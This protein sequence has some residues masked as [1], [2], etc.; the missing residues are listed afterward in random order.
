FIFYPRQKGLPGIILDLKAD[1][2]PQDAIAQIKQ[3][4]YSEKLK[5][6]NIDN[7]LAVGLNYDTH[8]KEHQCVIEEL[9]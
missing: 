1:K 5:R 3:K 9:S 8:K 2:S 7:I 4:E 6:E